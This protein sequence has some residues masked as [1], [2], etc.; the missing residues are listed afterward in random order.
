MADVL[1]LKKGEI[2]NLT[3]NDQ[4]KRITI[5]LG[6]K[7]Y[8]DLD[9]IAILLDENDKRIKTVYY[10]NKG[11]IESLGVKLSGDD[12]TGGKKGDCEQIYVD[13]NN[14]PHEVKTIDI[15]C[16]IF[17]S[18]CNGKT[19]KDVSDAYIRLFNS[20][21]NEELGKYSLTDNS[22]NNNAVF[23]ARLIMIDDEIKFKIISDSINGSVKSIENR[24][25]ISKYSDEYKIKNY[26]NNRNNNV[27]NT[28]QEKESIFTKIKKFFLG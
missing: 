24:Y 19:F 20:N 8:C 9:S 17:N 25:K 16:N 3:K 27:Q 14:L 5:G 22:G 28:N 23:F 4:L 21:T 12:L 10:A 6:W 11:N 1:N 13:L 26:T 7:T 18:D 2:L 15:Y